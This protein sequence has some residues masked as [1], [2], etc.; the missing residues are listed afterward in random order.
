MN[1][2]IHNAEVTAL[3]QDNGQPS[4]S[5]NQLLAQ[6]R[7]QNPELSIEDAFIVPSWFAQQT[8][9][10]KD[11]QNSDSAVYNYPLVFAIRGALD[12]DALNQSL[13]E[14][15]RRHQ[16]VRSVFRFQEEDMVQLVLSPKKQ[17]FYMIDLLELAAEDRE[18]RLRKLCS[19]EAQQ[20]FDLAHGPMLR[21]TL[22]RIDPAYHVL[23]L[24]THHLVHDDWSTGILLR[25]LTELY[26][27]L[28][29]GVGLPL[30]Y[31]PFQYGDYVRWLE[32]HRRENAAR[33]SYW[34][35]QSRSSSS[36]HHLKTDFARPAKSDNRG[37]REVAVL[38]VELANSL[39]VLARQERVSLFMALLAGF[40]ALLH[41]YSHD[42]EIAVASCAANRPL[43]QVEGLIGRFSNDIF[44]RTS[45][46]GNPTFRELFGRMREVALS[47]YSDQGLP[48]G[49]VLK[50]IELPFQIM[51]ILQN[52][53]R[54]YR[55]I[56]G[57]SIKPFPF[58]AGT[59]K[60]DLT[61]LLEVEPELKVTLEYKRELF[62]PDTMKQVL[63]DYEK[64]LRGMAKGPSAHVSNPGVTR[65]AE[66][67]DN[68]TMATAATGKARTRDSSVPKDDVESRLA[69]IWTAA[70]GM[71]V[72]IDQNLFEL[73]G[74]SLFA[75]R[76]FIQI[77]QAFKID[78]PLA[79]LAEAPTIR[80]LAE[81]ISGRKIWPGPREAPVIDNSL[82]AN[83]NSSDNVADL[84]SD[85][86][87]R[88]GAAKSG[89]TRFARANPWEKRE[90]ALSG[91]K[92]RLLQKL[93]MSI[94]GGW[95]ARVALHRLRGVHIGQNVWIGYEA[96]IETAYPDLVTI[97]NR[98]IIGMRSTILAHF[99]E[100]TGVWINDDA[101]IGPCAVILPGVTIGEGAV[102]T[103][104]SVVTESVP[105]MTIVQGNPARRVAVC[106][107]PLGLK[108]SRAE[109]MKR[110]K[111]VDENMIQDAR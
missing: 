79:L 104:G 64:V 24:T 87:C 49:E 21:T 85:P 10:L 91:I 95:R 110:L 111:K 13:T 65:K 4:E 1:S 40:K 8:T 78:L 77:E 42:D 94:P 63:D 23:Q 11:A 37:A 22:F 30:D 102:V 31:L 2:G 99:Q 59:A 71:P 67:V 15:Y 90:S 39:K 9:W 93:A 70:F 69:E 86:V 34:K 44:L 28:N 83:G 57:L 55:E 56:P 105:P 48:F 76:L 16:G 45:L 66:R 80:Q 35:T 61:V 97:G 103:A 58:Y 81:I 88:Y 60:Y 27:A 12:Q 25:E 26:H 33:L 36:F 74:D 52:A 50:G 20:P 3:N 17:A 54:D 5:S 43:P 53:H 106:G 18:L 32:Q 47:A 14:I 109:F 62:R 82:S 29:S 41:C 98:V 89:A 100:L 19:R 6:V 84:W 73:G 68:T 51:F 72:G 107:S 38:P 7:D 75:A 108:T 96:L 92:N 101:Y 46:A